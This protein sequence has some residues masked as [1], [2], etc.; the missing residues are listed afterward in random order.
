MYV[1]ETV[2]RWVSN[3]PHLQENRC[4]DKSYSRKHLDEHM[5]GGTSRVLER[6]S[7]TAIFKSILMRKITFMNT[8]LVEIF[9]SEV[10]KRNAYVSPV[11]AAL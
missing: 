10:K 7:H 6:I 4:H 1:Q 11:T 2:S 8:T 3:G 5:N 9:F